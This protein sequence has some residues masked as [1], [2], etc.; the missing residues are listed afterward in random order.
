[1]NSTNHR[2]TLGWI[3]R[4]L[5]DGKH[6]EDFGAVWVGIG[7]ERT[8]YG[9]G[10]FVMKSGFP[11]PVG[12]YQQP[13]LPIRRAPT[14][15]IHGWDVQLRYIALGDTRRKWQRSPEYRKNYGSG[16][17]YFDLH[18]GN[19]GLDRRGRFVAFDW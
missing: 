11:R 3:R 19:V 16:G 1:M 12:R 18:P 6:P 10:P 8:V 5:K 2:V 7:C 14:V 9:I 17:G 4:Q 15:R 13:V